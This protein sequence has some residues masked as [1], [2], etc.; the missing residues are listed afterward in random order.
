MKVNIED[1]MTNLKKIHEHL[2][3]IY[4]D[5]TRIKRKKLNRILKK[6]IEWN[7]DEAIEFGITDEIYL[8][9]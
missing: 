4:L 5:K 7:A 3:N 1:E 9:N 2:I 6:D 8:K